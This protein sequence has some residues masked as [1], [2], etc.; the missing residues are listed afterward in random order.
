[1]SKRN[2][3]SIRSRQEERSATAERSAA[4]KSRQDQDSGDP[5]ASG[6]SV[7][8]R[9]SA[10][11]AGI[12]EHFERHAF[13]YAFLG[14]VAGLLVAQVISFTAVMSAAFGVVID[15]YDLVAPFLLYLVLAPSL[16]KVFQQ[17]GFR[18]ASFSV[19][20]VWWFVRVRVVA[21]LFAI[22]AV[23]LCYGLPLEGGSS[24]SS[25]LGT[26][27]GSVS[28]SLV[29]SPYLLATCASFLT[30]LA[31][32][33]RRGRAADLFARLPGLVEKLGERI[34]NV[35]PLF[36][37]LVGIYIST[38]PEVLAN[39]F[40]KAPAGT[41]QPVTLFGV[42]FAAGSAGDI[43]L[44]YV[45][46]SLLTGLICTVWHLMLLA[47]VKLRLAGFSVRKYFSDYFIRIYPLL[48]ATSSETLAMPLNLHLVR[49]NFPQIHEPV[50]SVTVG[51][52]SI[53]NIN[54]TLISCFVLIPGL[55]MMLGLPVSV[56]S[57]LVC[58]PAVFV[59]GFGVP[60]MPGELVLFAGPVMAALAVPAELRP[61]FL[62]AFLGFQIGL[63]DSFRTGANSTDNGLAALLLDRKYR[64]QLAA[65]PAA[66][67]GVES[68]VA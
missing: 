26:S 67:A 62:L 23:S 57:L 31:L 42:S 36:T 45:L 17:S 60:G 6:D 27:L 50:A 35:V 38:L 53:L 32:A 2:A 14:L 44:I 51:L 34:T 25:A 24:L 33:P 3:R 55:C 7:R 5:A 10:G 58:L 8:R 40:A 28:R 52:G 54:G 61:L 19:Y 66:S 41:F 63:P 56:I 30:A 39:Q 9:G 37:F 68:E 22:A 15:S 64:A 49:R 1:M 11:R 12:L 13:A 20:T 65:R 43:F 29:E 59:I 21:C 18:G 46:L 47:V 4:P 48:W 16:V